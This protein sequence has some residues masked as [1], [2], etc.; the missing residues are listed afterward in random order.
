MRPRCASPDSSGSSATRRRRCHREDEP[1]EAET[2]SEAPSETSQQSIDWSDRGPSGDPVR[3][4]LELIRAEL[5]TPEHPRLVELEED[6]WWLRDPRDLAAAKEPL[7]ERLEWGIYSLLSTSGGISE[8]AFDERVSHLYRGPET[9][10]DEL[11]AATLASYRSTA[12]SEDELIRTDESLQRRYAEHGE[13]VGLLTD[14]AHRAG[15]RAWINTREQ[16]RRYGGDTL[17]DLLS[18]PE[19]RVYLPLVAPGPQEVLEQFDCIWYVRGKG[20]FLFDVEWQAALDEPVL[21]RGPRI[22][23]GDNLVRFL[24]VPDERTPLL[25]LR[26]ERSPVLRARLESDNWHILK[27]SNVRR[28]HASPRAD[29]AVLSP[30]LGLDPEVERDEDQMAM[31]GG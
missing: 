22:E 16:R 21:K 19:Q 9:A 27:W 24:V 7:S 1:D 10:D 18:E 30:L 3:L 13:M 5:R 23:S 2:G 14:F 4:T 12:E 20:A 6:L 15:M 8:E 25:R 26:L 29:L 28:L 11:I 31:F 17:G